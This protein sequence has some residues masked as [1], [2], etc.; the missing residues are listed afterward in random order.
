[1]VDI[2][3]VASSTLLGRDVIS[4]CYVEKG[5]IGFSLDKTYVALGSSLVSSNVPSNIFFN[6]K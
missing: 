6:F 2:V 3:G 1:L 5:W 4:V